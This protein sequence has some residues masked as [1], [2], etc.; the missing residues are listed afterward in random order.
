MSLSAQAPVELQPGVILLEKF[1]II[2]LLGVGGMGSVY[3][4]E[5]LFMHQQYALKCLNKCQ[6]NDI[7]WRRF[8]N[9]AQSRQTCSIMPISCVCL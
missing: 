1:K 4:V 9:E 3:R 5:H 7:N 6:R 2:E 8:E